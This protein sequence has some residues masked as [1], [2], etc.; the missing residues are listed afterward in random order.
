MEKQSPVGGIKAFFELCPESRLRPEIFRLKERTGKTKSKNN[1]EWLGIKIPKKFQYV[2][3]ISQSVIF[4]KSKMQKTGDG[5]IVKGILEFQYGA[6]D[7]K[8]NK[9]HFTGRKDSEG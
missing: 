7:T 6:S 5:E 1:F 4:E 8:G 2:Y 9:G 3:P